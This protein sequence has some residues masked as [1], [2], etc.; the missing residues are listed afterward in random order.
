MNTRRETRRR[1]AA[2][3]VAAVLAVSLIGASAAEAAPLRSGKILGGYI[4]VSSWTG[5][6]GGCAVTPDCRVW[7]ERQ[8]D[9]SLTGK[10]PALYTSIVNVR[11]LA[12]S[13]VLR[14][15]TLQ[16]GSFPDHGGVTVQFWNSTCR[17]TSSSLIQVVHGNPAPR[18]RIPRGTTWMTVASFDALN[19]SWTLS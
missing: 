18:F 3:V 9:P 10:D 17:P 14:Q 5:L 1:Q 6:G 15:V 16:S 13:T 19:M 2:I 4:K 7:L 11:N 8:C 12:G